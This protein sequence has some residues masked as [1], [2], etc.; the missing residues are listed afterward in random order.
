MRVL[1]TGTGMIGCYTGR[2][3]V[4]RGD[5][6]AFFDLRPNREYL[7]QV[8]QQDARVI[9][10]DVRSLPD[11]VQA[12]LELRPEVV[13]HTAAVLAY[14][15]QDRP[16]EGFSINLG[17]SLNVAEAVRLG[18]ARR[19]IFASTWRPEQVEKA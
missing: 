10:G 15:A 14:D 16:Y 6:V 17:G 11:L 2:E 1:I 13:I 3:L 12:V 8:V 7:G 5:E 9:R 18:G 4:G 19:L